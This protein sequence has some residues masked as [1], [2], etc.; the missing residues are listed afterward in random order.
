MLISP[1]KLK[2]MGNPKNML[3]D[4]DD[5]ETKLPDFIGSIFIIFDM[6]LDIII[7]IAIDNSAMPTNLNDEINISLEKFSKK[8]VIVKAGIPTLTVTLLKKLFTSSLIH[9]ILDIIQPAKISIINI[10]VLSNDFRNNSDL[11]DYIFPHTMHYH[12]Y[13][14]SMV[15]LPLFLK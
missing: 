3:F 11:L 13:T 6:I 9:P 7:R 5:I 2:H 12:I 8:L 10:K 15:E 1:N 14:I 4:T